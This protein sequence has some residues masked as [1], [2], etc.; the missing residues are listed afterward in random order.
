MSSSR[1]RNRAGD[2]IS[3]LH[4]VVTDSAHEN[5]RSASGLSRSSLE[6]PQ[7]DSIEFKHFSQRKDT[8]Q[9]AHGFPNDFTEGTTSNPAASASFGVDDTSYSGSQ[10]EKWKTQQDRFE[11]L[12]SAE[13]QLDQQRRVLSR[14][15]AWYEWDQNR[16]RSLKNFLLSKMGYPRRPSLPHHNELTQLALYFFPPRAKLKVI[17][18]D[19]GPD[20][21]ERLEVE[22]GDIE[23]GMFLI[24]A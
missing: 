9:G 10:H 17:I 6:N 2:H 4:S 19:Y 1:S 5:A 7:P 21:F 3:P 16:H 23:S 22:L 8:P 11:Q 15:K 12:Q 18:C 20:R 14:L 13:V 24:L